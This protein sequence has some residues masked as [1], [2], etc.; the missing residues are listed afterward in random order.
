MFS[1]QELKIL[2]EDEFTDEQIEQLSDMMDF[3]DTID[4]IPDDVEKL[5]KEYE[6][7]VPEDTI[8]GMKAIC[9][10]IQKD[11]KTFQQI[12]ALDLVLS[13]VVDIKSD[14]N[15]EKTIVTELSDEDYKKAHDK[16]FSTL[17]SLSVEDRKSFLRLLETINEEQKK[18]LVSRLIKD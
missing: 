17:S 16:F 6:N 13:K 2:K 8:E 1:E 9:E 14:K 15:A 11:P 7:R 3:A 10:M 5:V 4:A 12:V 18:D